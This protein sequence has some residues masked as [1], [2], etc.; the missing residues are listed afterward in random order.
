MSPFQLTLVRPDALI[1]QGDVEQVD[2]PGLEGDMGVLAGHAPIV[3][4]L[5]PGIVR[6]FIK[7]DVEKFVVMG[8]IA[9]LSRDQVTILADAAE[10]LEDFDI[11]L[12]KA[13][14]DE[15]ETGLTAVS[16]GQ[17]LD[18]EIALLDHYKELHRAL[19]ITTAM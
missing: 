5:R 4:T 11:A 12:L 18:R 13:E 16:I 19:T 3:T 9:E 17:E 8:G 2:L 15:H 1:F 6:V 14:I 7:N 10:R